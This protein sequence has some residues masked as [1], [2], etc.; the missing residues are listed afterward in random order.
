ML[1]D[2][3]TAW[4]HI[5]HALTSAELLTGNE[6][7]ALAC[8]ATGRPFRLQVAP[9]WI[10]KIMAMYQPVIRENQEMMYQ[11][12]RPYSFSSARM[13]AAFGAVATPYRTGL[14][15]VF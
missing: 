4:G 3:P 8:H 13:T 15:A 6:F 2:S 5:R 9:R 14:Q 1:V 12:E 7:V 10:L 11:F